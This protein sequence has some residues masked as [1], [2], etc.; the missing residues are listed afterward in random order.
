MNQ[1]G[2]YREGFTLIEMLIVVVVIGS[3]VAIVAPKFAGT[4]QRALDATV[5]SDLRRAAAQ[6]EGYFS[7]YMTYPATMAAAVAAS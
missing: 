6:S 3:L 4:R 5:V 1:Q 2:K 7:I